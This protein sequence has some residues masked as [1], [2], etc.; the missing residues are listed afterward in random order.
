VRRF[1]RY[2]FALNLVPNAF[3]VWSV[4]GDAIEAPNYPLIIWACAACR[5]YGDDEFSQEHWMDPRLSQALG[6][7]HKA[8]N[9]L[10]RPIARTLMLPIG[11]CGKHRPTPFERMTSERWHASL[12]HTARSATH[13]ACSSTSAVVMVIIL[14]Y[15][16][17]NLSYTREDMCLYESV[18][19]GPGAVGHDRHTITWFIVDIGV[20]ISM[21]KSAASY[22][23]SPASRLTLLIGCCRVVRVAVLV[24]VRSR[25]RTDSTCRLHTAPLHTHLFHLPSPQTQSLSPRRG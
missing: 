4:L 14:V 6:S 16:T 12:P 17:R 2:R 9:R 7:N 20:A 13:A 15:Q 23:L 24:S 22:R 19:F 21:C 10:K 25:G 18:S 11:Q 1:S 3:T 8:R 5:C